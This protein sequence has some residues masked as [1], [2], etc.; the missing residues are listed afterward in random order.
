MLN[1][2]QQAGQ[3]DRR[4]QRC[5]SRGLVRW[6]PLVT[7]GVEPVEKGKNIDKIQAFQA[8]LL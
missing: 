2:G 8:D 3:P 6:P 1:N 5:A 4:E 7:L